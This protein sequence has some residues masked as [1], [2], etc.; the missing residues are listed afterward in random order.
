MDSVTI[1][2][3]KDV[4]KIHVEGVLVMLGNQSY[5][6]QSEIAGSEHHGIAAAELIEKIYK[7]REEYLCSAVLDEAGQ[8]S[9]AKRIIR[10]R[11]PH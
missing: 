1:D 10:L 9:R 6:E 11:H 7:P 4:S 2:G 8:I 3:W 5:M